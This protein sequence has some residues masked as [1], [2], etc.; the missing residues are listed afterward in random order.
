MNTLPDH[1]RN[2]LAKSQRDYILLDASAS[3]I[4]KWDMVT[5]AIDTYVAS[6]DSANINSDVTLATFTSSDGRTIGLDYTIQQQ[7]SPREWRPIRGFACH[8]GMTPLNDAINVLGRTLAAEDPITCSI[9]IVTDGD[10]T[11]CATS[12]DQAQS[13]LNWCRAKGWQVTFLGCDFNNLKTAK[14]LGATADNAIGVSS[15]RLA[16]VTKLLAAKRQ[17]YGATG[18]DISFSNDEKQSFGG[19]LEAPKAEGSVS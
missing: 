16:E 4:D 6:L 1:T 12:S 5:F 13:I 8:H 17:R 3:M 9:L 18:E 7:T 11:A 19:Y 10:G 15:A 2:P 14:L